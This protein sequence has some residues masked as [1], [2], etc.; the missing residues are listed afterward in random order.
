MGG[1]VVWL[2]VFHGPVISATASHA[3]PVLVLK[4]GVKYGK[5]QATQ[6]A[7]IMLAISHFHDAPGIFNLAGHNAGFADFPPITE[8]AHR[9][10]QFA[11]FWHGFPSRPRPLLA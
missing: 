3:A 10:G 6:A 4:C 5:K 11:L 2:S 7:E 1:S 9:D 8:D